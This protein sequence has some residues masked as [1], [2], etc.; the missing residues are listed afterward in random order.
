MH[1]RNGRPVNV[2]DH[3]VGKDA[4]GGPLAGIV[5]AAFPGTTSC[6]IRV[7]PLRD[8]SYATASDCLHV[9]DA[10]PTVPSVPVEAPV[11]T[12]PH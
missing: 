1:Y 7:Y 10:V 9:E 11:L 6:N 8:M 2:G 12:S 4:S 3:V 5:G